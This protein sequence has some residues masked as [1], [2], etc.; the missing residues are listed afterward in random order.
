MHKEE[1][2]QERDLQNINSSERNVDMER[3]GL[4]RVLE[5]IDIV[6]LWRRTIY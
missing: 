5:G 1:T 2:P 6:I 3:C 4:K